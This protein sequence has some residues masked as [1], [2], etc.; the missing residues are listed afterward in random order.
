MRNGHA[1]VTLTAPQIGDRVGAALA[2][3][4]SIDPSLP[5]ELGAMLQALDAVPGTNA[6][7]NDNQRR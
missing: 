6:R 5:A 3:A 4:Y 1:E 7:A 2:A